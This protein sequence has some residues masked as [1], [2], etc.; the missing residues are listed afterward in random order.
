M[1]ARDKLQA[2]I[3]QIIVHNALVVSGHSDSPLFELTEYTLISFRCYFANVTISVC[4]LAAKLICIV[5]EYLLES[6]VNGTVR[7][8]CIKRIIWEPVSAI[9]LFRVRIM[10]FLLVL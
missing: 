10:A 9:D 6:N 5:G 1:R 7:T 2:L 3:L 4:V 8:A